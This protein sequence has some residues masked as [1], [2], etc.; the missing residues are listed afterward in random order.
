MPYK[1]PRTGL[2]WLATIALAMLV[3]AGS[4]YAE[5]VVTGPAESVSV[6]ARNASVEEVLA[7][8]AKSFGVRYRTK[9]PLARRLNGSYAGSLDRV[10]RRI[11]EGHDFFVK[12][13]PEGLE[14]V[15]IGQ[16]GVPQ[17]GGAPAMA[18]RAVTA[19]DMPPPAVTTPPPP[20]PGAP[21]HR[22]RHR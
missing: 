12:T 3:H 11:L 2:L 22:R 9:T 18:V 15:V 7:A 4:A 20:L 13:G 16:A 19:P 14:V 21:R 1:R 8:L 5:V 17:S 10:V 6:E